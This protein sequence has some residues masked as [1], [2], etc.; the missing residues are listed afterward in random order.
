MNID[1]KFK[2]L[3]HKF[4]YYKALYKHDKPS[5]LGQGLGLALV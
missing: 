2:C 1:I 5:I 4:K 3:I